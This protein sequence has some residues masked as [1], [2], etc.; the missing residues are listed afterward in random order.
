MR[1][2]GPSCQLGLALAFSVVTSAC[3]SCR[4]DHPFTP[5]VVASATT[6]APS[7]VVRPPAAANSDTYPVAGEKLPPNTRQFSLGA[8][9]ED[10]PESMTID[11][12]LRADWNEDGKVDGLSLLRAAQSNARAVG[13]IYLYDG[14]G[15]ARK[16]LDLPGWIPSS[17]DCTWDTRLS[18][19]GKRGA[20]VDVSVH[21]S[22]AMPLR[23]PTR[24][25]AV[26]VPN[27]SD[28]LMIDWRLAEP[29]PNENYRATVSLA[30][31]DGDNADDVTLNLEMGLASGKDSVHAEFVWLDR[32]AGVSKEPGHFAVSLVPALNA[33]EKKA[34]SRSGAF[35]AFSGAGLVWRML[36]SSC[37]ESATARLF[38]TDGAPLACENMATTVTRLTSIEV[39]AALSQNDVL[40]AAF[41]LA[42]SQGSFGT[43]MP[44]AEYSR[45]IKSIRK[46][47][48]SRD[49]LVATSTEVRP[50]P[51]RANPHY[52]PL[53]F[54]SDGT[55]LAMTGRGVQRIQADGHEA[56]Q[57]DDAAVPSG[58]PLTV[59]SSDGRIWES[60]VPSCDRSEIVLLSR[61]PQGNSARSRTYE[62]PC[63]A[64]GALQC[65][66]GSKL[67]PDSNSVR[68]RQAA[69]GPVGRR[70]FGCRWVGP[71]FETKST[72][73]ATPGLAG[74][75]GRPLD[76]GS[77]RGG[78]FRH[79]R[80]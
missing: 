19:V 21:C 57:S 25:L 11:S 38:A 16:L 22:S 68:R 39:R 17:Q 12:V 73:E 42:R 28:P 69:A 23:T 58:W 67:A 66:S 24:F 47:S 37:A 77:H 35:E 49:A 64:P 70:L 14:V 36:N 26:V 65:R 1:I 59:S 79:R 43:V 78:Y 72:G 31:R 40:R 46:A 75:A 54:Q 80:H 53:Q 76:G 51:S 71:M 27:R 3:D 4:R 7:Q 29:A 32:A 56:P 62:L 15:D 6:S 9:R 60:L 74:F 63:T 44:T 18:R 33:L 8:R 30:D 48:T 20:T 10:A 13:A 55:L 50:L 34:A 41:A 61:G 2:L 5:F 45:I 52:S